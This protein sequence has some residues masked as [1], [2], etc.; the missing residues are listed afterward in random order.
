MKSSKSS[1]AEMRYKNESM[2]TQ[3]LIFLNKNYQKLIFLL[4]IWY[5]T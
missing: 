1:S 5:Y 4:L 2:V 3:V